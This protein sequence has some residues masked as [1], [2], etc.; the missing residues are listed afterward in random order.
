MEPVTSEKYNSAIKAWA[1]DTRN[2]IRVLVHS[3]G[4]QDFTKKFKK[5][6]PNY[7]PVTNTN[8]VIFKTRSEDGEINTI[9]FGFPAQAIFTL[10]GVGDGVGHPSVSASRKP[11]DFISPALDT[12]GPEL[13]DLVAEMK[14]DQ[15]VLKLTSFN[16]SQLFEKQNL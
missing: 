9:K 16:G 14:A 7:K 2:D 8:N 13:A 6:Y 12:A 3:T 11:K 4:I 1:G 5:K 10:L 15:Q